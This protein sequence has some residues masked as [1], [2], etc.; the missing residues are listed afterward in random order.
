MNVGSYRADRSEA[1][2]LRRREISTRETEKRIAEIYKGVLFW[3]E[4]GAL[5]GGGKGWHA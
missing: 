3:R 4:L 1:W 5:R 2:F